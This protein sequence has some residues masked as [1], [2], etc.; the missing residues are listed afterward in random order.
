MSRKQHKVGWDNVVDTAIF[1]RLSLCECIFVS[2]MKFPSSPTQS[3]PVLFVLHSVCA[4]VSYLTNAIFL[5][6][7]ILLGVISGRSSS[8]ASTNSETS[9]ANCMT[10]FADNAVIIVLPQVHGT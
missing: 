7:F 9:Q 6:F 2:S 3:A 8:A 1:T 4:V 5:F 10:S